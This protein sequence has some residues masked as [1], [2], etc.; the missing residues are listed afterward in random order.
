EEEKIIRIG[1]RP[2]RELQRKAG[3]K[4]TK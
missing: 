2:L 4:A 1:Y 3:D